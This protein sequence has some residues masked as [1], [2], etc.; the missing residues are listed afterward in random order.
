MTI[1]SSFTTSF[2]MKKPC[3]LV[4]L[5]CFEKRGSGNHVKSALTW[6]KACIRHR[7]ILVLRIPLCTWLG[8]VFF[9][10]LA[11]CSTIFA[12]ISVEEFS[13]RMYLTNTDQFWSVE[14]PKLLWEILTWP[15]LNKTKTK[16]I[17]N[18]AGNRF[19]YILCVIYLLNYWSSLGFPW[20]VDCYMQ[21]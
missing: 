17:A 14:K 4:V 9:M 3:Y 5:L 12:K 8:F 20:N 11:F 16:Y 6:P 15:A 21:G 1:A 2:A 19:I 10:F 13:F 7:L 18:T